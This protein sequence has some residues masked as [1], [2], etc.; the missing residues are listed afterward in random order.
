[1]AS[2]RVTSATNL[3]VTA[4]PSTLLSETRLS[5]A[6]PRDN[7]SKSQ[8]RMDKL[9]ALTLR[10]SVPSL[11]LHVQ[12]IAPQTVGAQ[13]IRDAIATADFLEIFATPREEMVVL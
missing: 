7:R 3:S 4:I 10:T 11:R 9:H 12:T 1:M 6:T 13:R 5:S 2:G 8:E